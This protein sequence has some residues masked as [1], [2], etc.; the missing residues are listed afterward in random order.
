MKSRRIR[1][2]RRCALTAAACATVALASVL[3]ACGSDSGS[4]DSEGG[5]IAIGLLGTETG[6]V[7]V[8]CFDANRGAELAVAEAQDMTEKAPVETD[9]K[10]VTKSVPYLRGVKI[11]LDT[12]DDKAAAQNSVTGYRAL[13]QSDVLAIVGP[14]NSTVAAAIQP[15]VDQG[16]IP[17]VIS[18][19]SGL[20]Y[21]EPELAFR[22][23]IPAPYFSGG[24]M[25][26]LADRGIKR[27]FI[28]GDFTNSSIV[29]NVAT[30]KEEAKEVGIQIVGTYRVNGT[31]QIDFT[32]AIEQAKKLNPDAIGIFT[33]GG[34]PALMVT[35]FRNAGL[36]QPFFGGPTIMRQEILDNPESAGAV[37][38]VAYTDQYEHP[39]SVRFTELFEKKFPGRIPTPISAGGYDAMW[40][41]LRAIHDGGPEKLADMPESEAR[42]LIAQKLS[43]QKSVDGAQGPMEF[44]PNGDVTGEAAVVEADGKGGVKLLDV[45][46]EEAR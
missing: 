4:S 21:V 45:P 33:G 15:M 1:T 36:E 23:S 16:G 20:E 29:D 6:P 14:C 41:V 17:Q 34:Q 28:A 46:T 10:T 32:S 9:G 39:S 30:V 11:E 24:V 22:G 7:A 25:R 5:S 37:F 18:Y 42:E 19:A 44:L 26:V 35:G 2:A 40:R 43:E 8:S 12:Q 3:G 27:V 38:S 31:E 13:Q